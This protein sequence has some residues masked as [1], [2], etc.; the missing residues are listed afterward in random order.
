VVAIFKS[1]EARGL[2]KPL[3]SAPEPKPPTTP[4]WEDVT[5]FRLHRLVVQGRIETGCCAMIGGDPTPFALH[6]GIDKF[7]LIKFLE[8]YPNASHV[9]VAPESV[10]WP[11]DKT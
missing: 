6:R 11:G 10:P 7:S 9:L 1:L 4:R 8:A 5:W 3:G 2:I